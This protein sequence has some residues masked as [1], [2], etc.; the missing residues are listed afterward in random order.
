MKTITVTDNPQFYPDDI[1]VDQEVRDYLPTDSLLLLVRKHVLGDWG[2]A[3]ESIRYD[4]QQALLCGNGVIIS[5]FRAP[6]G[7]RLT[8]KTQ[9]GARNVTVVTH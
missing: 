1:H 3:N 7:Y 5:K 4:N 8:V 2:D 6:A 9:I